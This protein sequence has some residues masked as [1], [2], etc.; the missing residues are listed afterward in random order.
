MTKSGS[1]I[2][3]TRTRASQSTLC[4]DFAPGLPSLGACRAWGVESENRARRGQFLPDLQAH[5]LSTGQKDGEK[6]TAAVD[7]QPTIPRSDRL[8][9]IAES[10]E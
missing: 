4:N 10:I 6:W 9:D 5:S 3:L 7:L 1:G 8:L 2:G